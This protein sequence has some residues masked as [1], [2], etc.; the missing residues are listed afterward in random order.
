MFGGF[1]F[2]MQSVLGLLPHLM[3]LPH[4]NPQGFLQQLQQVSQFNYECN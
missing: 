2:Y 3:H 4:K 1:F